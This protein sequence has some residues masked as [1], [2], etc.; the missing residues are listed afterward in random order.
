ANGPVTP[1]AD[2]LLQQRNIVV[3]P[4]IL[5]NAGG[6]TVSYFEW[7][8][9]QQYFRWDLSRIR[10]ELERSMTRAFDQVWSTSRKRDVSLRTAAYLLAID[11]VSRAVELGGF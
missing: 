5:A 6:V 8:Q 10:E 4:D 1:E 7:V 3:L 11:R 2:Q 9:N